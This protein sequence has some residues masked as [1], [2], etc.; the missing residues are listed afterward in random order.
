MSNSLS[1]YFR[2]TIS[3]LKTCECSSTQLRR[4][5]LDLT[6]RAMLSL[7]YLRGNPESSRNYESK[8]SLGPLG[9]PAHV[10]LLPPNKYAYDPISL[11]DTD[12]RMLWQY[13]H[14]REMAGES[15]TCKVED[16]IMSRILSYHKND[17]LLWMNPG[18]WVG[19]MSSPPGDKLVL[20]WAV[21]QFRQT[22]KATSV[23]DH[24]QTVTTDWIG[25]KVIDVEPRGKYLPMFGSKA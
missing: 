14:M 20:S 12:C 21:P 15:G 22:F 25:N 10:P 13:P 9:I 16:G 3:N 17:S 11:C 2:G 6:A 18:A 19:P 5:E 7:N 1:K 4:D 24:D 8:F 23:P